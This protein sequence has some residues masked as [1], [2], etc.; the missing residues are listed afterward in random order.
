VFEINRRRRNPRWNIT[1]DFAGYMFM[2]P[3]ILV[4]GTF[5]VLPILYEHLWLI[6]AQSP[7]IRLADT[8]CDVTL[9][10]FIWALSASFKPLTE[11]VSGE[12]NFFP[13]NFTLDNYK[14]IFLQE[15]LFWRWLNN[16]RGDRRQRDAFL[17][18]KCLPSLWG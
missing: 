15:P 9:I 7:V 16:Q 5:V 12:P 6:L 18:Q 13:K 11:I 17:T 2:M 14:Q 4:L 3:T 8:L 10:P 1:E